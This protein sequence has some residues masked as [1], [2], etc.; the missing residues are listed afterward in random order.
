M[1]GVLLTVAFQQKPDNESKRE[2]NTSGY[3][4]KQYSDDDL[5]FPGRKRAG[6]NRPY[7]V[8]LTFHVSV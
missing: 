2:S 7:G 4:R 1:L 5:A 3:W 8:L 6:Q